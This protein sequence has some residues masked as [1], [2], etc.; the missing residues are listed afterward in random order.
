MNS[1]NELLGV[2]S[3]WDRLCSHFWTREYCKSRNFRSDFTTE[4]VLQK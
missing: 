1:D 3:L 2:Q 4:K